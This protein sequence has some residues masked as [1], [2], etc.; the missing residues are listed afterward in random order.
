MLTTSQ[1]LATCV[2]GHLAQWTWPAVGRVATPSCV[3]WTVWGGD[4]WPQDTVSAPAPVAL[5]TENLPHTQLPP[6]DPEPFL[7]CVSPAAP[8][9]DEAPQVVAAG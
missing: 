6:P 3:S 8:T 9:A 5:A 1:A 4:L 7:C 2:Q